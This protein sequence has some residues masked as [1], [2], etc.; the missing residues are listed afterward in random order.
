MSA[1]I[2]GIHGLGNKAPETLLQKWWKASIR[3]GLMRLGTSQRDFRFELCYWADVLYDKPLDPRI[4]DT[5]HP[6]YLDEPYLPAPRTLPPRKDGIKEKIFQ[7]IDE[8]LDK[9]FL[10]EDN[11]LNFESISDA[12]IH[13]YF[14]DLEIYYSDEQTR[15]NIRRRLLDLLR[16]HQ[17]KKIMLIAHS[18]GSIIAYDVLSLS[19]PDI[20]IDYFVTIGSPLGMPVVIHRILAE[21]NGFDKSKTLSA[22]DNI[23]HVWYNFSDREDKVALDHT[24]ADDFRA[25]KHGV[26]A[27]D[28]LVTN[29]YVING[30]RNP[31]KSFGY[32]R[33][34]ELAAVV[35]Q[36]LASVSPEKKASWFERLTARIRK[37]W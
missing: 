8:Q 10:N 5:G 22:P 17:Q 30:E 6:L 11:T 14:K 33:T 27:Q 32:L 2:L 28:I 37:F 18:M 34:P 13:R 31:H 26:R 23:R 9:V 12:I 24:V 36:F 29:N 4:V 7:L 25:N 1:I 19:V 3:E 16:E 15:M 35:S 21:R 20:M